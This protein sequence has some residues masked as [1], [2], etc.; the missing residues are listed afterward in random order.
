MRSFAIKEAPSP[1]PEL[2]AS[3]HK[4]SQPE[5]QVELVQQSQRLAKQ[6][7]V[8]HQDVVVRQNCALAR[9]LDH[10]IVVVEHCHD[11]CTERFQIIGL[12]EVTLLPLIMKMLN[13]TVLDALEGLTHL[14]AE[15]RHHHDILGAALLTRLA[16]LSLPRQEFGIL[17]QSLLVASVTQ[18]CLLV[19]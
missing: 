15:F 6:C 18:L 2:L 16:L 13:V 17:R 14:L 9:T 19:Q 8:F 3:M 4:R 1:L 5:V 10:S 12:V 11:I 7:I